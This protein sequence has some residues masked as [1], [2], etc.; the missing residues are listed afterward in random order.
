MRFTQHLK[1]KKIDETLDKIFIVNFVNQ[2][3]SSKR[4]YYDANQATTYYEN[5][6]MASFKQPSCHYRVIQT[7]RITIKNANYYPQHGIKYDQLEE[8]SIWINRQKFEYTE[9]DEF[10]D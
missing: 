2:I 5:E 3:L 8:T 4:H 10:C 7:E 9:D 1:N 6:G